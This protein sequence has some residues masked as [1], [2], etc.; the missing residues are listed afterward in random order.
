MSIQFRGKKVEVTNLKEIDIKAALESKIF[1]DWLES[2][3]PS[4]D[5][6]SIEIQSVDKF[7]NNKVGFVKLKSTI[8]RN[9]ASVPGIVLLRGG[10]VA[11]LIELTCKDTGDVY[12]VLTEQPRVPTGKILLELPAGMLDGSGDLKNKA[13]SELEEEVGLKC[14][15]K[16]LINL[17]KLCI[18]DSNGFY[19]D[20]GL[21]DETLTIYLWRI[22]LTKQEIE[23][24]KGKHTG[25][26][27][28]QIVLRI[29]KFSELWKVT[30][31]M[32]VQTAL[33]LYRTLKEENKI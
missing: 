26:E 4:F 1:K 9:G 16:D 21:L 24:L 13:V 10:S 15:E 14:N 8:E 7:S 30:P 3:D 2:L 5:L 22:S 19:T 29:F 28:E 23:N 27:N 6:K 31:S 32:M 33:N 18:P 12:S 11:V 17:T 20:A 25:I